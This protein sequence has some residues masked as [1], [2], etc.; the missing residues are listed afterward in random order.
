MM[1]PRRI[2]ILKG[3]DVPGIIECIDE[4]ERLQE[5]VTKLQAER[6]FLVDCTCEAIH[7]MN[8][9]S[10]L[11]KSGHTENIHMSRE[12]ADAF[13]ARMYERANKHERA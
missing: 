4:I 9:D 12:E 10:L 7:D 8:G 13:M 3:T 1:S 5:Q 6:E 11:V 2:R